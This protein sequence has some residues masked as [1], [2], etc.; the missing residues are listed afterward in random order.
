MSNQKL[1]EWFPGEVKPVNKG[2][3]KRKC[4][5]R[6]CQTYSKWN[7]KYWCMNSDNLLLAASC[8]D[9]SLFQDSEWR[10]L[11]EKPE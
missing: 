9:Q 3:H 2:V 10:G 8:I 1:T 6:G 4:P 5:V 7:G 11:A